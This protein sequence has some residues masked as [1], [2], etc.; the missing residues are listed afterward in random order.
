MGTPGN[1]RSK[2]RSHRPAQR[3]FRP[4]LE[5][6]EQRLLPGEILGLGHLAA[7]TLVSGKALPPADPKE[8]PAGGTLVLLP[9]A[10]DR[11]DAVGLNV[12][13]TR[14]APQAASPTSATHDGAGSIQ[15]GAAPFGGGPNL[16]DPF[17]GDLLADVFVKHAPPAGRTAEGAAGPHAGGDA[18]GGGR[19]AAQ[20]SVGGVAAHATGT[21]QTPPTAAR[22]PVDAG[23]TPPVVPV[24]STPPGNVV[25]L[26]GGPGWSS[27]AHDAQ[28]TALADVASLPLSDGVRWQ[29]PVDLHPPGFLGIHYGTPEITPNNT[30]IVPVK[31]TF[32]GDTPGW[33]VE[34]HSGADG[35]LMWTQTTTYS[36]PNSYG[37]WVPSYSGVLTASGRYYY[38]G[39]GGTVYYCDNPDDE[40]ATVTGQLAF[41]GID[42]YNQNPAAFNNHVK[43]DTPLTADSNGT[44]Y[45]GFETSGSAP[46]G[47]SSGIARMDVTG[48]GTWVAA[49]DAAGD[50][51]VTQP[52][53]GS[54][55][56][57]SN[58]QGTLYVA[59]RTDGGSG[60]LAALDT[61]TLA[62]VASVY[63]LDPRGSPAD[64]TNLSTASPMVGW[65]GDV[66]YGVLEN[67][68][69]H[70]DR[71]WLLHFSGDLSQTKIPGSF[72]W[73]DTP[74]LVPASMV[75]DY[76]GSSSYL[77]MCKYN[78]YAGIGGDGVNK[79][80]VLDPNATEADPVLP[81]VTVMAEVKTIAG[82][83]P[84]PDFPQYPG[85][86]REWCINTAAVD[87]YT[88]SILVNSEDGSLY[89]WDMVTN[90][91][92][93]SVNLEPPTSE[94]YT[95]TV[96]G[97]D[98]TVYAINNAT[99]FA[100]G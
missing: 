23:F 76:T 84:D 69:D 46:L 85:A 67:P 71:G 72:G 17:A 32:P 68:F 3:S 61:G 52:H 41:Y 48:A 57:L 65:D 11:T 31:T 16:A 80:A 63:L 89:R 43:I 70:N 21:S 2:R 36:P 34:A 15:S 53:L 83:T 100:V 1:P 9:Q 98:G 10:A 28:H 39:P 86:V 6:I 49:G 26:D 18:G 7:L 54:A 19:P 79:I 4:A 62:R 96:V 22:G 91:F 66:Y 90:S 25:P 51:N 97:P 29:T 95:P 94:A 99:L 24:R 77:L 74:S 8:E 38:P 56:A 64:V 73:D 35:H 55:P 5:P 92:T 30:V 12:A 88:D 14:P 13:I 60:Y 45:F 44:I 27:Y 58:D 47:L 82:V 40:G 20:G 75:P 42:N 78:N 37:S 87:Q 81:A 33:R 50:S 59:V 93:E